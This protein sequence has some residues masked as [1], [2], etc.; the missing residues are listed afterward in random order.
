M[1]KPGKEQDQEPFREP[2]KK[3]IIEPGKEK[4]KKPGNL[5]KSTET[6]G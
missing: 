5:V 1:E 2:G 6:T 4:G 3:Q